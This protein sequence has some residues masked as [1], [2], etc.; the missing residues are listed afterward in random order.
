[1]ASSTKNVNLGVCR[2]YYGGVDCG[3]TKGGVEVSVSTE[4]YKT[5]VD[6]YGK[7]TVA[8]RIMGRNVMAKLPLVETNIQNIVTLMPGTAWVT[9]GVRAS[10]T[11]TFGNVTQT[12]TATINGQAFTFYTSGT[13]ANQFAVKV[14]ATV[15]ETIDSFV[16]AVNR[17]R[18]NVSGNYLVAKQTAP[19][20]V[21]IQAVDPGVNTASLAAA[22]GITASGAALTG[23]VAETKS[24]LEGVTG[25][26]IN[27]LDM[28]QELR[29]HPIARADN[30]FSEDFVIYKAA[31]PGSLNFAYKI[32]SERVYQADFT[33]YPDPTTGKLWAIGTPLAL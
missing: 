19:L 5:E 24:R 14:G 33:G 2:A 1:M 22:S 6:Q 16:S 18:L 27:L 9:D 29:L 21:T 31:T 28:A 30:D 10:G 3:L 12:T 7:S 13:A 26:G 15:Q 23:G 11:L 20:V 17:A 8:E 32:D 4:T 25:I